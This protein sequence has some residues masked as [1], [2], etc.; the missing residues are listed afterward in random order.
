MG[1]WRGL[2]DNG[3]HGVRFVRRFLHTAADHSAS[4]AMKKICIVTGT[5]AEYGLLHGV[6][7][8]IERD[9]S[10]R[11]QVIATAAHLSHEFGYTVDEIER[12]GFTVDRRV[13]MLLSGDTAG[14]ITKSTGLA[15]IGFSDAFNDLRPDLIVLL[16]DR[17]EILAAATAALVSA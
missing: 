9:Q 4:S 14:A 1:R 12:D 13:E 5:R 10:L 6:M 17:Y 11:L 3:P 15:L 7:T 16:G 2:S 8:E